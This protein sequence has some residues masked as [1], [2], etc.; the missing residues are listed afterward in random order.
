MIQPLYFYSFLLPAS[1]GGFTFHQTTPTLTAEK[2]NVVANKT[3]AVTL[4]QKL[5]AYAV[6]SLTKAH[7]ILMII[8]WPILAAAAIYYPAYLKAVLSKKGE[9]FQVSQ[10]NFLF[11]KIRFI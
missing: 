10:L 9:W 7:G 4:S 1:S 3:V 8:A 5:S 2:I 6:R 11:E